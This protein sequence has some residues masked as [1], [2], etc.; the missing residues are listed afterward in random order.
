[1]DLNNVT[2]L[3]S[4]DSSQQTLITIFTAHDAASGEQKQWMAYSNDAP[5]YKHFNFYQNNPIIANPD[6]DRLKDF[7][8]PYVFQ[9]KNHF[10]LLVA[11]FNRTLI[12]NSRD[13]IEWR[14]VSEFGER[15]GSHKGVWEC[16]SLFPINVTV[17]E[18]VSLTARFLIL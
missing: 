15:E 3:G 16:P 5:F 10:V 4:S 6:P 14:F 7:R 2:G 11:A 12:Y 18:Y 1:M 13:L 9:Y 17:N 8:D